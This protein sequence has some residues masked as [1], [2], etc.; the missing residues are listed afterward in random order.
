MPR[1]VTLNR[2]ITGVAALASFAASGIVAAT[3]PQEQMW[4]GGLLR[5]GVVLTAL[6]ACLP[7]RNREA[8]WANFNPLTAAVLAGALLLAII[9]PKIGVPAVAVLLLARY[10]FTPRRKRPAGA[11]RKKE[12]SASS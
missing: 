5:A 1:T 10:V 3:A 4:W 9:R 8:A 12:R 11:A 2:W 7:T 6:W